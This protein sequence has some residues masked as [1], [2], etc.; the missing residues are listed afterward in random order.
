M[1]PQN[2]QFII[3][4][5]EAHGYEAYAVGGC[6]R[7]QILGRIPGDW[8]ITTSAKPEQ[9]KEIFKRT[10]D[11]GLQ[12][13]TITVLLDD[14][15]YEVTTY[16]IDG[17]YEDN[18]HPKEV[19]YTLNLVEDLKRRDFTIN[20]MAY[21][22]KTGIVD[23]FGGMD[24][25]KKGV[26]R[27]VGDARE[28]FSEDALR[29]LRAVRFSAQ[30]G[31]SI[32]EDTKNA[33]IELAGNLKAISAERIQVEMVKLLTSDHPEYMRTAWELKITPVIMSDFDQM[34]RTEQNNPHHCYNVGEHTLAALKHVEADKVLR[35]AVLFHDIGKPASHTEVAGIDH[36][37]GHA[38]IGRKMTEKILRLW[39]FDNDTLYKVIKLVEYH[40]LRPELTNKSVRKMIAK[41]GADLFP[42]LLKVQKADI[43]GQSKYGQAEKLDN[44]KEVERIYEGI[45][46]RSECLSLKELAVTGSDLIADGMKPG[47][48]M[49]QVLNLLLEQVIEDPACNTKEYLMDHS[50][51]LR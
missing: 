4:K 37:Y 34:M 17:A 8:D 47:K 49:G 2:V 44:L 12:H 41:V 15:S 36:F 30:L 18:R 39:K 31:F 7:D 21:N 38:K 46:A 50:R 19:T 6:V 26:I 32:E 14:E 43:L 3:S 11:T 20:A 1:L 25:I 5:L 28:R 9:T 24:D 13:G 48:E 40:D 23:I 22:E 29:I 51:K 35:L 16:R 33:I 42:A 10:V 27:C 45:M